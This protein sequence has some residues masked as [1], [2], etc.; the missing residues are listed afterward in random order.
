MEQ[1]ENQIVLVILINSV[2]KKLSK[3]TKRENF[4]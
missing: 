2:S 4:Y 3:D 1:G